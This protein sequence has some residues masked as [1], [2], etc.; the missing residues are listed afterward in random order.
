MQESSSI[1]NTEK[2]R[3]RHVLELVEK[4]AH[5]VGVREL[6]QRV[7]RCS[8]S[9]GRECARESRASDGASDGKHD[10]GGDDD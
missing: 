7:Q 9:R 1:H 6:W 10:G 5:I 2:V 3:M 8:A 4:H